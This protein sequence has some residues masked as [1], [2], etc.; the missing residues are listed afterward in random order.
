MWLVAVGKSNAVQEANAESRRMA[1]YPGRDDWE[2]ARK[3]AG[4]TS[5]SHDDMHAGEI[6]TSLLL[7]V[8]PEVV[9]EGF[10]SADHVTDRPDLLVLGMLGYTTS[11]VIGRPS[12]ATAAKGKAVLE[13]LTDSFRRTLSVLRNGLPS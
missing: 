10:A 3:Q 12:Q 6:E 13:S 2:V 11:G 9:G 5:S 8:C 4:L 1:L 7:H